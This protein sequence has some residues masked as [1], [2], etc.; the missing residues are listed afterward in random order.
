MIDMESMT[1]VLPI[2][3]SLPGTDGKI[4]R[5][6]PKLADI[7]DAVRFVCDMG[8]K[9]LISPRRDVR[10]VRARH[11]Y[12]WIARKYTVHGFPTIARYCGD[13]DHSTAV[14]GVNKIDKNHAAYADDIQKVCEILGV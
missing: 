6:D 2:A 11:I 1:F 3:R 14:H 12:F 10:L 4:S 9:E 8:I 7:L 5:P 13:R